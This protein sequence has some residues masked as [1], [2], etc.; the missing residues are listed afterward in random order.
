MAKKLTTEI[1]IERSEKYHG[2]GRYN[3]SLV[4]YQGTKK[5]VT[6]ICNKCGHSFLQKPENHMNGQG[7]PFC[8]KNI[9]LTTKTFIEEC[10]KK[11]KNNEYDYSFVIY[12]HS[13]I[14]VK[15]KCN[16][17]GHIFE[18]K[19]YSHLQGV[20]CPRC[21][22]LQ[23]TS[24]IEEFI[25]KAVK[26]HGKKYDYS[27][28]LYVN[29]YT[30][31]K[32]KCNKCGHIFEQTP[33]QHLQKNGCP[34]CAKRQQRSKGEIEMCNFIKSI[35]SGKILENDRTQIGR[36]ELD[37]FLPEL[38][39]AFEYNGEYWHDETKKR[40]P[41]YHKNKQKVCEKKGIKL[42]EIWDTKW[43]KDKD[44]FKNLIQETINSIQSPLKI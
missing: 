42:I 2:I 5:E 29:S 43:K 20:G 41:G 30:K 10:L 32:I 25:K 16:K 35:Y 21:K 28:V 3:Y 9:K 17:C 40:K 18:Q 22:V 27:Y 11:Y 37:V 39:L 33:H 12:T 24:T 19:P 1:F 26:I 6:I 34:E 31:I 44:K 38:K 4:L 23:Q 36:L 15:I 8:A 14:K 7:C 13:H